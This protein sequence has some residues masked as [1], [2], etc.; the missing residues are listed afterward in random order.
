[1]YYFYFPSR[2]RFERNHNDY[3]NLT[4]QP[5]IK[6]SNCTEI[7][8]RRGIEIVAYAWQS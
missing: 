2:A 8:M 6:A 4:R 3:D 5:I 1:M 7:K